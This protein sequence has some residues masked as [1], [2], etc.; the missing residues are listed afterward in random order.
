MGIPIAMALKN[1]NVKLS[2][3]RAESVKDF[4]SKKGISPKRMVIEG[5]GESQP[6]GD[7]KSLKGRLQNRRVEIQMFE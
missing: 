3:R 2:I 5:K 1:Y 4:L 6:I 7:N